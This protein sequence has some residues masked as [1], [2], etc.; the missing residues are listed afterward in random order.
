MEQSQNFI[1]NPL[2]ANPHRGKTCTTA[3]DQT[4]ETCKLNDASSLKS[5]PGGGPP[6]EMSADD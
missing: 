2:N 4:E 3:L 6:K 5:V 1:E